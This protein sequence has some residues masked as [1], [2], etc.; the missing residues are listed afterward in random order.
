MKTW[1]CVPPPSP[2][3]ASPLTPIS[4][5]YHFAMKPPSGQDTSGSDG[6]LATVA[7]TLEPRLIGGIH[8]DH[9]LLIGRNF[10]AVCHVDS[11]CE[12]QSAVKEKEQGR[13]GS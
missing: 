10:G 2:T 11:G 9:C 6:R 3:L 12:G 4:F 7:G 13:E 1:I 8:Y 5:Q